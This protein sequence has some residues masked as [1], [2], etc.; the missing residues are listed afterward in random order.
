MIK[1]ES[2]LLEAL[3]DIPYP[4][5][6]MAVLDASGRVGIVY[7]DEDAV[8]GIQ[9]LAYEG[10]PSDP[11]S[12]TEADFPM[13]RLLPAPPF[14]LREAQEAIDQAQRFRMATKREAGMPP[15]ARVI[16]DLATALR[17]LIQ[18]AGSNERGSGHV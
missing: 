6:E 2:E 10:E 9:R 17:G 1:G 11:V 16:A 13:V 5:F 8:I 3:D 7:A 12:I 18:V 14:D 15:T 4:P